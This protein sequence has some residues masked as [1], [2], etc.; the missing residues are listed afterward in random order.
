[1][2]KAPMMPM[3]KAPAVGHGGKGARTHINGMGIPDTITGAAPLPRMMGNYAKTPPAY[4]SGSPDGSGGDIPDPTG[5]PGATSI[6]GGSMK[7]RPKMGGLGPG[8]DGGMGDNSP[9][10][11]MDQ[12]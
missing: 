1:M 5:H 9:P 11:N 7:S 12:T 4:L 2:A 6:R 10:Q 3:S 8:R